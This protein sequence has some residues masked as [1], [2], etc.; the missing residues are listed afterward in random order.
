MYNSKFALIID[1]IFLG[2]FTVLGFA[3]GITHFGEQYNELYFSI[4]FIC[5]VLAKLV[6]EKIETFNKKK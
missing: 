5:S 4:S 1:L 2:L 3:V 6:A